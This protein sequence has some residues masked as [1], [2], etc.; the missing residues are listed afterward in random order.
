MEIPALRFIAGDQADKPESLRLCIDGSDDLRQLGATAISQVYLVQEADLEMLVRFPDAVADCGRKQPAVQL[1]RILRNNGKITALRG[2]YKSKGKLLCGIRAFLNDTR[3]PAGAS[4]LGVSSEMFLQVSARC[5]AT[6][7]PEEKILSMAPP[8]DTPASMPGALLGLLPAVRIPKDLEERYLGAS[9]QCQLVRKLIMLAAQVDEPVLIVGDTGT[10]KEIVADEI[11]MRSRRG[12]HATTVNCGAL[13]DEL[14]ESELYGHEKGSFTSATAQKVGLWER[15]GDGTLFLDEVGDL[16][17]GNQVKVLR[18]L[19]EGM[20]RRVGGAKEFRV[21]AR[22]IA[23]THR[24]LHEMVQTGQF[25]EDLYYRLR[26]FLIPTPALKDHPED[27]PLM[28]ERLWNKISSGAPMLPQDILAGL[29]EY[30]WPGNVRELGMVLKALHS[31]FHGVERLGVKHLEAIYELQGIAVHCGKTQGSVQIA[32]QT[33]GQAEVL[34]HLSK[35]LD[36]LQAAKRIFTPLLSGGTFRVGSIPTLKTA[37]QNLIYELEMYCLYPLR[38]G[39][40]KLFYATSSLMSRIV[41][42]HE[43]LSSR[44]ESLSP[45]SISSYNEEL[46]NVESLTIDLLETMA[47]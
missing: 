30:R 19:Q 15:A 43:M 7:P 32:N 13:P 3:K 29:M 28:A 39:S 20:I 35:I 16:S 42:L 22:V 31:L 23:A 44:N 45:H 36:L 6:V 47:F 18:A 8:D 9:P 26:C 24:D 2:S 38:F 5:A 14:F 33:A 10:G 4:F 37:L 34:R 46:A 41:Y 17:P 25:R 1:G 11:S 40:E 27:I 21:A 12:G